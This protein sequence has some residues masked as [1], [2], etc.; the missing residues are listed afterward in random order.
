[1][2]PES[3]KPLHS[4]TRISR[5]AFEIKDLHVFRVGNPMRGTCLH[6]SKGELMLPN[7][8]ASNCV[9]RI[10]KEMLYGARGSAARALREC[11]LVFDTT[12]ICWTTIVGSR[13]VP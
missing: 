2:C 8:L 7:G 6:R 3:P 12:R 5:I 10:N 13:T 11:M 4:L 9:S 1:M